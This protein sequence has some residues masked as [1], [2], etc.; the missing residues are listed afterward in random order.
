GYGA[1]KKQGPPLPLGGLD[2]SGYV[3]AFRGV[4]LAR[5]HQPPQAGPQTR[6]RAADRPQPAGPI[7]SRSPL[8][9]VRPCTI[10]LPTSL[11]TSEVPGAG[12]EKGVPRTH[13]LVFVQFR[14]TNPC[15]GMS[16]CTAHRPVLVPPVKSLAGI[17]PVKSSSVLPSDSSERRTRR[18]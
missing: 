15:S 7:P 6:R 11:R 12:D 1:M 14:S 16:V 17:A 4:Q 2:T 10:A 3:A 8:P 9:R 13:T 5:P 18:E